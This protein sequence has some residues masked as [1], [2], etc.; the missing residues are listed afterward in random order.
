MRAC[1]ICMP[2][3]EHGLVMDAKADT[4]EGKNAR[5]ST[6]M[7]KVLLAALKHQCAEG[8][9]CLNGFKESAYVYCTTVVNETFG[10]HMKRT[11]VENHVKQMKKIFK[12]LHGLVNR[13]GFG[14]D[15][16]LKRL[17]V[18]NDVGE[19]Y[20][21]DNPD[22][23]KFFKKPY[24]LYDDWVEIFG[25]DIADGGFRR[26]NRDP[27]RP[28]VEEFYTPQMPPTEDDCF[29][30]FLSHDDC[31]GEHSQDFSAPQMPTPMTHTSSSRPNIRRST[32]RQA[33]S[34]M[35]T[36][37]GEEGSRE[38]GP[39]R[40]K[41]RGSTDLNSTINTFAAS[42]SEVAVAIKEN[43]AVLKEHN[44]KE[45]IMCDQIM[46]ALEQIDGLDRAALADIYD[47]LS[48]HLAEGRSFVRRPKDLR[49]MYVAKFF[50]TRSVG[51]E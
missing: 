33:P 28:V 46:E 5:W 24:E 17:T 44:E 18:T 29:T 1:L 3:G 31:L 16:Q 34:P 11:Q 42:V 15:C 19:A 50:R 2:V 41:R 4:D 27:P 47:Y 20:V 37:M 36:S 25:K 8:Q 40:R 21:R 23:G 45:N 38:G 49:E 35:D 10:V 51:R 39:S 22:T 6:E 13:S 9:T 7:D 32:S 30:E 12:I 48:T 43:T 26:N 14:W